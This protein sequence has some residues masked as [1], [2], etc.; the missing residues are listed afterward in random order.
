MMDPIE[1][2][3]EAF[4]RNDAG[5]MDG[6][7]DLQ[8]PDCEWLTPAGVLR[9]HDE[10]RAFVQTFRTAFPD[11]VHLLDR[12]HEVDDTVLVVQGRWTGAQTG[13]LAGPDGA[14]PPT[15]RRVEVAFA[16]IGER[17]PGAELAHR[18]SVYFDQL[19]MLAQLGVLPAPAAA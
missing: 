6:F 4:R 19:G 5:D 12:F 18:V 9:G 13:P 7:M 2:V 3:Q 1:L 8:A 17:R 11:G 16:L 15:G 10:V 14:L